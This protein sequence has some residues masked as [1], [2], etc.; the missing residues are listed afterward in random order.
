[1]TRDFLIDRM[2]QL[3]RVAAVSTD[4]NLIRNALKSTNVTTVFFS[5]LF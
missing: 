3:P 4:N 1:M 5:A 2:F